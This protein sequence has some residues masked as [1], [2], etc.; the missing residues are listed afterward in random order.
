[1]AAEAQAKL[2]I[3]RVLTLSLLVFAARWLSFTAFLLIA[4]LLAVAVFGMLFFGCVVIIE[5]MPSSG[6]GGF[7]FN[8]AQTAVM[9]VTLFVQ[10]VAGLAFLQIG[11]ASVAFGTVQHLRGQPAP[12]GRCLGH[13][14][15]VML[16]VVG[17]AGLAS[18]IVGLPLIG[19]VLFGILTA[20]EAFFLA[21]L[22]IGPLLA[23]PF[24]VTV[25]AAALERTGVRRALARSVSLT[26]GNYLR[27][28]G[29][30][31][32]FAAMSLAAFVTFGLAADVLRDFTFLL[33][34]ALLLAIGVF[35]AIVIAVTYVE[36]RSI[37]EGTGA[38]ELA[39]SFD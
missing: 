35:A 30:L 36:L 7:Y 33:F 28:L 12:F 38:E 29:L 25:P 3:G 37:K 9:S 34:I 8:D 24:V 1:M 15:A 2:S 13:G 5:A 4:A 6:G 31:L 14:F 11:A 27:I 26:R 17:A 19:V 39:R 18:L 20:N 22:V 32:L 23:C 21:T 10:A 16:P